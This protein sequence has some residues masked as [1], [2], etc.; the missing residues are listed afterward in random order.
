MSGAVRKCGRGDREAG[1]TLVEL[2]AA[3]I[4][5]ALTLGSVVTGLRLLGRSGERGSQLIARQDMLSRGIDVLRRDVERLERVVHRRERDAAFVFHGDEKR[6]T[7]VVIEPPVPSEP[8]PYYIFYSI[9]Q[10]AEGATLLRSRA[11]YD[12]MAK[13]IRRLVPQDEVTVLEGPYTLRFAY[14]QREAGRERWISPWPDH[15]RLPALIKLEIRARGR[16]PELPPLVFRPR[17]DAEQGCIK[18]TVGAC[19]L[20]TAGT[21]VAQPTADNKK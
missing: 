16:L 9:E 3:L 18:D 21:L 8:G 12:A 4:V 1:F 10:G 6:L 5:I 15:N 13:D 7:F 20:R 14:L 17:I 2:L 19:T 11:P